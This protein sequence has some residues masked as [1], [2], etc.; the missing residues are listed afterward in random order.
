MILANG[1]IFEESLQNSIIS[2]LKER[3]PAT[4]KG[5]KL[6]PEKI[7]AAA[8]RLYQRVLKGE[9]DALAEPLLSMAHLSHETFLEYAKEFSG[10]GLKKKVE[11]ELGASPFAPQEVSPH[12]YAVRKPLGVLLHIAAGNVDFL[13][14]YSVLEGLLAG[15][16]NLLKLPTGDKGLSV[17]LL[18]ELIKEEPSLAPYIYVFDV[19][20]TEIDTLKE[21]SH[22]ADAIVVW[23][24][25]LAVKGVRE[26]ADPNSQIIVWGHK[27]S[28]AYVDQTTSE[29]DLSDL[30]EDICLSNQMLCSSCQGIYFDGADEKDLESFAERFIAVLC[31][32]NAKMGPASL[33]MRAK[34]A[35]SLLNER[36]EG[37][38]KIYQKDGVS[39]TIYPD[40]ELVLSF[41]FRNLWIKPLPE[42]KIVEV[43]KPYRGYLQSCALLVD[44]S[45]KTRVREQLFLAGLTRVVGPHMS[46]TEP[47]EAHDGAYALSRYT[48][49]VDYV[50]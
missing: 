45:K 15:N 34:S 11:L 23:G 50:E 40:S 36:M 6:D 35:L 7:Y 43:L 24:G 44:E 12:H 47:L 27:L 17:K 28:F 21:L 14:A 26:F 20:S 41:L 25:D 13:P 39:A 37:R 48:R 5:P 9:F 19:P 30:A 29:E 1:Q 33:G 22:Y 10:A 18:Q 42:E 3:I 38:G 32:T 4:L 2:S 8:E 16:I 46:L 49:I 31:A